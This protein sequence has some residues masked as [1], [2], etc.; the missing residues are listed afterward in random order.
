MIRKDDGSSM[1]E[2]CV[3]VLLLLLIGLSIHDW[4]SYEDHWPYPTS[5]EFVPDPPNW[6]GKQVLL[7]ENVTSI[8]PANETVLMELENDAE[9][10][11]HTIEVP[12]RQYTC[13]LVVWFKSM[14]Y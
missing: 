8:D 6:E 5:D 11:S 3:V 14:V 13:L 4:Y 7:L 2:F 1:A 9:T 10:L 12:I